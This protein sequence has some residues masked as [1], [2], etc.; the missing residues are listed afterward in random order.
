MIKRIVKLTI[1]VEHIDTFFQIFDE[2]KEKILAQPGCHY[3]EMLQSKDDPRLC[4]T[5]SM[6]D[7]E[8]SLNDYRKSTLFGAVW[9]RT[10]ALFDGKPEAWSLIT[11][12]STDYDSTQV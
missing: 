4:F 1:K 2:S 11:Q 3:V 6:W 9:P 10:K 5:Y 7:D 8:A 12:S